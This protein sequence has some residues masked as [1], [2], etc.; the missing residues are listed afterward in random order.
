M[1]QNHE[2]LKPP[3]DYVINPSSFASCVVQRESRKRSV[4]FFLHTAPVIGKEV[5]Y[6]HA[7]PCRSPRCTPHACERDHDL[8]HVQTRQGIAAP[9]FLRKKQ[10]PCARTE[11][12]SVSGIPTST[13]DSCSRSFAACV[14]EDPS[15][16]RRVF[17]TALNKSLSISSNVPP[18]FFPGL[19]IWSG[20]KM[21]LVYEKSVDISGPN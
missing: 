8:G 15:S 10:H 17:Y 13:Q 1:L 9:F 20:S 21:S 18:T 6:A 2:K 11:L 12:P 5:Y 16:N 14:S 3:G 7:S 19:K 4:E